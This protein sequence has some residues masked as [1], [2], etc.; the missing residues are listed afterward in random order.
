MLLPRD[1]LM[2][3]RLPY[4]Y[5]TPNKEGAAD[6]DVHRSAEAG[7]AKKSAEV[8]GG[9]KK[10][11]GADGG[12]CVLTRATASEPSRA[13]DAALLAGWLQMSAVRA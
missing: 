4:L 11:A 9:A 13:R 2:C 12:G 8:E 10:T 5:A 3:L 7:G 6:A 1:S